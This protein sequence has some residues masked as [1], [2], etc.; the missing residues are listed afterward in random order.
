L[1]RINKIREMLTTTPN[2]SFL[3]HAL[4]LEYIKLGDDAA[5]QN[6][7]EQLLE[8]ESGYVGSYYHLGKLLERTGKEQEAIACYEKGMHMAKE[9]GD[10]HAFGE[11][12]G[13]W[14]ELT[15]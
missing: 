7:F 2:D 1:E 8:H 6:L 14:E 12:R 4:A 3:K 9:K 15:F 10:Q 5:A 11:L 13:A